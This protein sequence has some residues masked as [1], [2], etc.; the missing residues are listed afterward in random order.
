M[1]QGFGRKF[2]LPENVADS[3]LYKQA[4][5]SVVV[6]VIERIALEIKSAYG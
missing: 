3:H 2:I 6:P 1:I 4:G 5:N